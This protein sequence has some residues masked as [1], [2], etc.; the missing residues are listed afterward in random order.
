M[1][2]I[3]GRDT[4]S[5]V[6]KVL[7]TSKELGI[8]YQRIDVGG[9]FGGLNNL[10]FV[11]KNPHSKI[12]VIDDQGFVLFESHAICR[13][14]I[15]KYDKSNL[16]KTDNTSEIAI[17]DQFVDWVHTELSIHMIPVLIGLIRTPK[18]K[19]NC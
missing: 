13:Y 17:I 9:K 6:Q 16:I 1:I 10:D 18:E 12:P 8:D 15:N 3:W 11:N 7:W 19:R 4:S 5:N 14:L 2:K